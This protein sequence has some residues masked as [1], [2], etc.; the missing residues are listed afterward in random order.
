[1][2][3]GGGNRIL[4]NKNSGTDAKATKEERRKRGEIREVSARRKGL[5][6]GEKKKFKKTGPP[7]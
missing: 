6:E 3:E 4:G 7:S 5:A 2:K 1:V